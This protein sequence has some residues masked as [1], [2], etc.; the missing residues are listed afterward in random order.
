MQIKYVFQQSIRMIDAITT[1]RVQMFTQKYKKS[2]N[3]LMKYVFESIF[4]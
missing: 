1:F 2:N 3:L 4:P